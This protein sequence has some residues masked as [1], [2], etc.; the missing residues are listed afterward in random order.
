MGQ[1]SNRPTTPPSVE[2]RFVHDSEQA[3]RSARPFLRSERPI[4]D[5]PSSDVR[6]AAATRPSQPADPL[7]DEAWAG[8]LVGV[9]CVTMT[10]D[11]LKRLRVDHRAGFLLSL[12]DAS[13]DLETIVDLSAMERSEVLEIIRGLHEAGIV[14]FR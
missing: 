11:D 3:L 12:M 2:A 1:L 13:L 14:A 9:L 10:C 4:P 8:S 5:A 7:S 6:L